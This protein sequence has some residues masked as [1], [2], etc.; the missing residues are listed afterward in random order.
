LYWDAFDVLAL[1][2]SSFVAVV[3]V[4]LLRRYAPAESRRVWGRRG[5]EREARRLALDVWR[6]SKGKPGPVRVMALEDS[7][8][9][10]V[11]NPV[12]INP[13]YL[14]QAQARA[15]AN[16]LRAAA[17][18]EDDDAGSFVAGTVRN[19]TVSRRAG[20]PP[21]VVVEYVNLTEVTS[22]DERLQLE[23]EIW[24]APRRAWR[25]AKAL[26]EVAGRAR[27]IRAATRDEA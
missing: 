16:D 5:S 11:P 8:G 3:L 10:Y 13:V 18:P 21:R 1:T 27:S 23:I 19:F 25:L 14:T 2:V 9:G 7:A 17:H 20:Y 22:A 15:L 12:I 6:D 26:D 24:F 4:L